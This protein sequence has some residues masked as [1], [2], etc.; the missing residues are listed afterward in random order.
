MI[1]YFLV[2][3]SKRCSSSSVS[4]VIGIPTP[5]ILFVLE[6][7]F[8]VTHCW[9]WVIFLMLQV[10]HNAIVCLTTAISNRDMLTSKWSVYPVIA[11][12]L[13]LLDLSFPLL[14]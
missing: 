9:R 3:N 2:M 8:I 5:G 6:K 10:I 14:V 13:C 1:V 12:Q 11:A 7:S 4:F